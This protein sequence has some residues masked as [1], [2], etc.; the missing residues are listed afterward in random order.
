MRGFQTCALPPARCPCPLVPPPPGLPACILA[1]QHGPHK[2]SA[3][4]L[5]LG[6]ETYGRIDTF[7]TLKM[8][9]MQACAGLILLFFFFFL[10]MKAEIK[11][12]SPEEAFSLLFFHNSPLRE[13][14]C[15][16]DYPAEYEQRDLFLL[17]K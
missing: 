13:L 12:C 15:V 10:Q 9:L 7:F 17:N 8:P 2:A 16:S 3:R 1:Q 4:L 11:F 14:S 6:D 5:G